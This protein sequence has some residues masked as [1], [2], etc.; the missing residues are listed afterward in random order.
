MLNIPLQKNPSKLS[1]ALR[2]DTVG[3]HFMLDVF[4]YGGI[5]YWKA[6][7]ATNTFTLTVVPSNNETVTIGVQVYTFK[8]TLT[9]ASGE[10]LIGGS[11]ANAQ[12]NL[13]SAI[14]GNSLVAGINY[15]SA[16]RPNTQVSIS[17]TFTAN[18]ATLT[19]LEAGTAGNS[20]GTTETCANGSFSSSTLLGG[21]NEGLADCVLKPLN[22]NSNVGHSSSTSGSLITAHWNET[23]NLGK[24]YGEFA[25][26]YNDEI[27][28]TTQSRKYTA[29][30]YFN[31]NYKRF[32][33]V[34][35][36]TILAE[37]SAALGLDPSA[38][39]GG[40]LTSELDTN[41]FVV[42]NGSTGLQVVQIGA[43]GAIT[44]GTLFTHA[45]AIHRFACVD[46][47]KI[48]GL[49]NIGAT[50]YGLMTFTVSG[51]TISFGTETTVTVTGSGASTNLDVI[52]IATGKAAFSF[53]NNTTT[54]GVRIADF[55]GAISVTG[56]D[57]VITPPVVT[58]QFKLL[59]YDTDKFVGFGGTGTPANCRMYAFN[60]TGTAISVGSA[61]TP[62]IGWTLDSTRS[63]QFSAFPVNTTNVMFYSYGSAV[64]AKSFEQISISTLAIS[65]ATSYGFDNTGTMN[66]GE[67]QFMN[68]ATDRWGLYVYSTTSGLNSRYPTTPIMFLFT[69]SGSTV[70]ISNTFKSIKTLSNVSLPQE[71]YRFIKVGT[72]YVAFS[73]TTASTSLPFLV[74][75]PITVELYNHETLMLSQA[76][77][78]PFVETTFDLIGNA[79]AEVNDEVAFLKVKNTDGQTNRIRVSKILVEMES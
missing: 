66:I 54:Y 77:T 62:S 35:I 33:K 51:T 18:V 48:I 1:S 21:V 72:T 60:V 37:N 44:V 34:N 56:S 10:V 32:V 2:G 70:S 16:T 75:K 39:Y 25:T 59:K 8:T 20:I 61:Y 71:N 17:S 57:T 74:W 31:V 9:G 3:S 29:F 28:T 6:I 27:F 55:T 73:H 38:G 14:N 50:S 11:L 64:G 47:T 69:V 30:N 68:L 26:S 41:K 65:F 24:N 43:G 36:Q 40:Y 78:D 58:T 23:S 63:S 45:N 49:R 4:K 19:A 53:R 52:K 79:N 46:T 22:E 7:K 15:S 12:A 5:S 67:V 13:I 42:S 76:L